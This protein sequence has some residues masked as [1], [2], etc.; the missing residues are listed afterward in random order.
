VIKKKTGISLGALRSDLAASKKDATRA[1]VKKID[2]AGE[3]Q[4][5]A[6][7]EKIARHLRA[8]HRGED[9]A[10][11][12]GDYN[13]YFR[14]SDGIWVGDKREKLSV[15]IGERYEQDHL[16]RCSRK[17]DY[18]ALGSHCY[19]IAERPQFFYEAPI[20]VAIG[21]DFL[22]M[23]D[24]G[25][26]SLEP[27]AARHRQKV[28]FN[29]DYDPEADSPKWLKFLDVSFAGDDRAGQ[30]CLLQEIFGAVLLRLMPRFQ[31]VVAAYGPGQAGK[32]TMLG[33]LSAFLPADQTVAICPTKWDDPVFLARLANVHLN[34]VG[35]MSKKFIPSAIF[36]Q[37]TGG[38][39]VTGKKL[40]HNPFS[41]RNAASHIFNCNVL[42]ATRDT[43]TAFF[44][45]WVLLRFANVVPASE[46]VVGLEQDLKAELPG[47]LNWAV[48]GAARL[49]RAD[50]FSLTDTHHGLM[51]EWQQTADSVLGF[52]AD[53]DEV[54]IVKGGSWSRPEAYGVYQNWC[55][56]NGHNYLNQRDFNERMRQPDIVSMGVTQK[57]VDNRH[58]LS[59]LK[60]VESH[61][62]KGTYGLDFTHLKRFQ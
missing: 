55:V 16:G 60:W 7:H 27:L 22:T 45:R 30:I 32:S 52:L 34:I 29:F 48:E 10:E 2:K 59:G 23:S 8:A 40:F 1:A 47:I 18:T 20:G 9:G 50:A 12:V 56:E 51:E 28:R 36:K 62:N 54:K 39:L 6:S 38:D 4:Q 37:F 61:G 57:R 41:F 46:R 43:S 26:V 5:N 3:L 21:K 25:E 24:D 14:F 15:E 44:R 11:P 13:L 58:M 35:E 53:D 33:V 19:D 49:V 17:A 31:T 42:P